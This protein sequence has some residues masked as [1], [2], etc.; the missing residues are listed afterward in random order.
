MIISIH[1]ISRKMRKFNYTFIIVFI[2]FAESIFSQGSMLNIDAI[3]NGKVS[4]YDA[5][6][7]PHLDFSPTIYGDGL[8]YIGNKEKGEVYDEEINEAYFEL[9]YLPLNTERASISD[10][11]P[12]LNADDVHKG[13][14]SFSQQ[15]RVIFYTK[16]RRFK[17]NRDAVLKILKAYRDEGDWIPDGEFPFNSDDFS[18]MHPAVSPDGSFMIFSSDRE[19]GIG[20]FDLIFQDMKMDTGKNQKIWDQE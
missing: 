11:S 17:D 9:K 20:G 12:I 16:E 14:C 10:F 2:A 3:R 6:N 8:V 5:I 18:N 4:G 15:E 13:P 1:D 7:S 19:G